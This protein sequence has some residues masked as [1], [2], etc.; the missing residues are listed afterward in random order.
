[1]VSWHT[2]NDKSHKCITLF[3]NKGITLLVDISFWIQFNFKVDP[4]R[5]ELNL[6]VKCLVPLEKKK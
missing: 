6:C 4:F 3:G 2:I 1:M 5:T